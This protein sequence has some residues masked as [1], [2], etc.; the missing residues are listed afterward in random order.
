MIEGKP[1]EKNSWRERERE[2]G[3]KRQSN[4]PAVKQTINFR[5]KR[6]IRLIICKREHYLVAQ[7][8]TRKVRC[9]VTVKERHHWKE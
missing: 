6:R 1:E 8:E 7:G 4:Q 3:K 9:C 2:T 5:H